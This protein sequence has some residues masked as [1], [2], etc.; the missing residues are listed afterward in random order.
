M[1]THCSLL[2]QNIARLRRDVRLHAGHLQNIIDAELDCSIA[3][4]TVAHTQEVLRQHIEQLEHVC[5]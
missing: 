1:C 2:R 3:A 4:K 5:E